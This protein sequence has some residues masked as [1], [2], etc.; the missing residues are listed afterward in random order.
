MEEAIEEDA[1]AVA[2]E[3]QVVVAVVVE[4]NNSKTKLLIQPT[5]SQLKNPK[6]AFLNRIAII[7]IVMMLI[8]I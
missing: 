4:A 8:S 6:L 1:E 2:V 7:T 3:D 5:T